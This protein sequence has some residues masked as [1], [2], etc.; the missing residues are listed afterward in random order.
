ML[1]KLQ[2]ESM[3]DRSI[4]II[5]GLIIAIISYFTLTGVLQIAAY[6][7]AAILIFTAL[8]GFCLIYK[9]LGIST[10]KKS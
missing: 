5:L 9:I 7:V 2:N 1:K 10:L 4:R 3:L 6:V 8:T